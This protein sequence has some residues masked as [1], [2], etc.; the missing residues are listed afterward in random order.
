MKLITPLVRRVRLMAGRAVIKLIDDA[1]KLQGAQVALLDGE[2]RGN[3]ERFQEYGFTS[4]PFAGAEGVYLS[5][6]ASRDHG[7]LIAVD[8]RR[9]RPTGLAA[10]EAALYDDQGQIIH[11]T[12]TGIVIRGAGKPVT[13]TDAPKVRIEANL[14]V[15]GDVKDRCDEPTGRTMAGMRATYDGH[16]HPSDSGGTTGTPN[17]S[18]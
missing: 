13:I 11:I 8:D 2:V 5:L 9:H 7:V 16:N 17:Q 3:V 6:C 4:V 1:R 10:G 12:R 18:M 14:E 15:T